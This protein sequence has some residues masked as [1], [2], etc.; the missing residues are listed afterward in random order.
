MFADISV[1]DPAA[2]KDEATFEV[3]NK[4]STGIRYVFVNGRAVVADGTITEERPGR[5]LHGP[6]R[7]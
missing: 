3:P 5:P 4:Y 7:R 6:G 2:V 1:F